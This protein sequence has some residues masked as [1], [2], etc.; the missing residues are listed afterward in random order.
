MKNHPQKKREFGQFMTP[1]DTARFM[2]SL[3]RLN[4]PVIRL[5]DAGAGEGD[6]HL[7]RLDGIPDPHA[8]QAFQAGTQPR[9]HRVGM[10][11][12]SQP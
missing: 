1:D 4:Q 10:G 3:F 6:E 11:R 9:R 12:Q 7:V 8:G 2:A 5:L